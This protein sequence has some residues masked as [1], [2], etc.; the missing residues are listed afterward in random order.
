MLEPPLI[1][2]DAP[3]AEKVEATRSWDIVKDFLD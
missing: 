2:P 1:S 3:A